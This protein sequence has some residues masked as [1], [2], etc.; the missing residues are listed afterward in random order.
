MIADDFSS[1]NLRSCT[2][3]RILNQQLRCNTPGITPSA[4]SGWPN[5]AVSDAMMMSHIIANSHPPPRA[6]P[7]TAAIVGFL[8][9]V[10]SVQ[11]RNMLAVYDSTKVLVA[12]SLISAPAAKALSDPRMWRRISVNFVEGDNWRRTTIYCTHEFGNFSHNSDVL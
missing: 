2:A 8:T 10:M 4:I 11:F 6:N 9:L 5:F 7:D 12:I 3:S 1:K